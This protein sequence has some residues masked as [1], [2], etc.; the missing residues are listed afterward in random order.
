M[1]KFQIDWLATEHKA[2]Q[3]ADIIKAHWNDQGLSPT[4]WVET[5]PTKRKRKIGEP[6]QF[7]VRSNMINGM[8]RAA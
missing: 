2:Q 3:L 7:Q 8:P 1:S 5:V 4:V 6:D